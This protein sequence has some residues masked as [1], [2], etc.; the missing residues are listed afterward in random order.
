MK[1]QIDRKLLFIITVLLASI[2]S[3]V[4]SSLAR[5]AT[6][7]SN[8]ATIQEKSG[9]EQGVLNFI[10]GSNTV[11]INDLIFAV[12][13]RTRFY[14]VSGSAVGLDSFNED[15]NVVFSA[16]DERVLVEMRKVKG[17]QTVE[18]GSRSSDEGRPSSSGNGVLRLEN[19]VWK[20]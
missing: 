5:P 2:V 18:S 12:D 20:N 10:H 4:S 16:S 1:Q 17:T 3:P 7:Q 19:G 8:P 6:G 11:V 14:A 13:K 9:L 15:Q